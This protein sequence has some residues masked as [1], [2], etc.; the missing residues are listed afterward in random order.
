M[1]LTEVGEG[2]AIGVGA[3]NYRTALCDIEGNIDEGRSELVPTPRSSDE[4]F[5]LTAS[6]IL[7][8]AHNGSEWGVLGVPGPVKVTVT[9]GAKVYQNLRVTNIPALKRREGFDPVAEM[10]KADSAVE[11]LIEDDGF[12]FLT[13]NDGDLAVQAAARLFGPNYDDGH[14]NVVG[15]IINGT[16]T[17]GAVAR[18]DRRFP[19]ARLFHTDPGLWE[20]GHDPDSLSFPSRTPETTIS[21]QAIASHLDKPVSELDAT[22]PIFS[23]VAQG[24]AKLA[25]RLGI[26]AGAELVVIS[27]GIGIG[28]QDYY[29]AELSR[30]LDSFA[31]SHNPMADKVPEIEYPD[32]KLA[33]TYELH[34]ARG[35]VRS[36][37][38]SLAIDELVR[39]NL[40]LVPK[41]ITAK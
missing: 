21:G 11:R 23:E 14:Y 10:I 34:G 36:H 30:V 3:T 12:T 25:V 28:S 1:V 38:V 26:Y 8:A 18:R 35:A 31:K 37:I 29:R 40:S 41:P 19:D 9:P 39:T 6:Q 2:L 5:A 4:F 13:V 17:G 24:I 15:D 32:P 16:G 27:G 22:D 20:L 33:D 7:N